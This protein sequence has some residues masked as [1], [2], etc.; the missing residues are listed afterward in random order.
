MSNK[1]EYEIGQMKNQQQRGPMG[2]PGGHGPGGM[3]AGEKTKEF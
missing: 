3:H 1:K 2:G